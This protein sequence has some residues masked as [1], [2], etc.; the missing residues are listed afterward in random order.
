MRISTA[1]SHQSNINSMIQKQSNID[2]LQ[3][4]ISSGVKHLLPSDDPV[5][6]RQILDLQ[7]N[8]DTT[9]QYQLNTQTANARNSLEE[10]TL[11]SAENLYLRAQEI[12]IA[13]VNGALTSDNKIIFQEEIDLIVK[14]FA[15]L[16]NTTNA[17]GEYIFS[18][19]LPDN[20]AVEW[21]AVTQSYDYAGG[22]QQRK[23]AVDRG[24]QLA[25]GDLAVNVFFG[26]DSNSDAA[27]ATG[28]K[29]NM[30][31]T[32]QS[33]SNMLGETYDPPEATVTGGALLIKGM[34]YSAGAVSFDLASDTSAVTGVT[35][36]AGNYGNLNDLVAAVNVGITGA[37]LAAS[38]VAHVDGNRIGFSSLTQG[39]NSAITISNDADG[40]LTDFGF[41]TAG[42]SAVGANLGGSM[43]GN[44]VLP[45]AYS[46]SNADFTLLGDGGASVTIS[47]TTD[48][49]T[50]QDVIDEINIQIAAAGV[51]NVMGAQLASN[52]TSLELHSIS[53]GG[54]SSINITSATPAVG[55]FLQDAG[56]SEGQ[57]ANIA[58]NEATD[59]I[60]DLESAFLQLTHARATV[61]TRMKILSGKEEQHEDLMLNMKTVLSNLKDVDYA[62]AISEFNAEMTALQAAQQTYVKV[63]GLSL[64]DY[65]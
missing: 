39:G 9:V 13:V 1:W 14:D 42:E 5:A 32:L 12:S 51:D 17:S 65:L 59:V 55:T 38:V 4:E 33:L 44:G 46:A 6:T 30:F 2:T 8:I 37:G 58:I 24:E 31:D 25:E 15:N 10:V 54:D 29:R 22:N 52:G 57:G 19:E 21:N 34:D 27:Q 60:G 50:P 48:F 45:I 16:V 28:G 36:A 62:Q 43:S 20:R 49:A 3:K 53:S 26:F 47:L 63:Q 35:I 23:I 7:S 41:A 64:F 61:G 11:G 18:G 56:F 40:V